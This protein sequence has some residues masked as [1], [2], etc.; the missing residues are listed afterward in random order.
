VPAKG[1]SG[2][3]GAGVSGVGVLDKSVLLL[4]LV[5]ESGS[6]AT[7]ELATAAGLSRATAYRLLGALERHGLLARDDAGLWVTG[8]HHLRWGTGTLTDG[9]LVSA[10]QP[11]LAGLRDATGESAQLYV[12]R[13]DTRVCVATVEP[14]S[15]LRDT[16]PIGAVF[17]LDKGSGGTVLRAWADDAPPGA[18][19]DKVRTQ[20]WA[21]SLSEREAGVASVSAPVLDG[22]HVLGAVSVSGPAQRFGTE[23]GGTY[24]AEV[25]AAA[26]AVESRLGVRKA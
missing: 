7:M 12:R 23:A 11:V 1:A 8:R 18:A 9:A 24:A 21:A 22:A 17:P 20:G 10:A 19:W 2:L 14:G 3:D 25:T 4:D 16:V 15:G 13:G 6:A 26:R 5:A